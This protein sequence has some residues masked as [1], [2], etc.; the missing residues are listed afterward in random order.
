MNSG[1]WKK[2]LRAAENGNLQL[3][4][5]YMR[6]GLDINYKHP[7]EQATPLIVSAKNGHLEIVRYLLE[8][9]ADPKLKDSYSGLTAR[10][11]AKNNRHL[12]VLPL[13]DHYLS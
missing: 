4:Q 3:L 2:I 6:M 8:K 1:D 5:L 12:D 11:Y 7:E 13:L 10:D 9:G